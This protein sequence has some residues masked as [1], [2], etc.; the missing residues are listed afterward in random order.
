ML[1]HPAKIWGLLQTRGGLLQYP[2]PQL[3]CLQLAS[4]Y[5]VRDIASN[6]SSI[7]IHEYSKR[8]LKEDN[9]TDGWLLLFMPANYVKLSV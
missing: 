5:I 8:K 2:S 3:N 1:E 6:K 9:N 7:Y 4:R